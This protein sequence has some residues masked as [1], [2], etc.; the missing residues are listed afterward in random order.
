M[1]EFSRVRRRPKPVREL[2][3]R[4]RAARLRLEA[5]IFRPPLVIVTPR[6]TPDQIARVDDE[7]RIPGAGACAVEVRGAKSAD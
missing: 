1:Q 3:R 7:R 4:A 2:D 6:L 5:E